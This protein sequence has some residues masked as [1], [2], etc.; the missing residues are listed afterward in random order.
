MLV[1]MFECV[2]DFQQNIKNHFLERTELLLQICQLK[3]VKFFSNSMF[4]E[5]VS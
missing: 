2:V 4:F 5:M 3:V 1:K